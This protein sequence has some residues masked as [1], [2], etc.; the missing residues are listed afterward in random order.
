MDRPLPFN[1]FINDLVF[2]V[3]YSV[4]SNYGDDNTLFVMVKNK[5]DIKSLLL[6]DFEIVNDWF[7]ENFMILNPEKK[8]VLEKM[9]MIMKCLTLITFL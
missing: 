9:L 2:F 4:L 1:L 8:C 6:L 7:Y 5:E 3:Q